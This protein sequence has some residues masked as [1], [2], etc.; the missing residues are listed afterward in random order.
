MYIGKYTEQLEVLSF[1]SVGET[2]M[3]MVHVLNGCKSLTKLEIRDSPFGYAALLQDV[4]KYETMQSLWMS[5]C[6]VTLGGCMTLAAKMP[7]FECGD[8][9]QQE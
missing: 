6:N 1:A 7:D 2:D 4:D 5:C 8:H 9:E 3:A